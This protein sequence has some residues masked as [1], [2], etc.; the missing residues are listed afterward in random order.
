MYLRSEK[1]L[2]NFKIKSLVFL[3]VKWLRFCIIR[4]EL[5]CIRCL[6]LQIKNAGESSFEESKNES[7]AT[8]LICN[9]SLRFIP[10]FID[11]AK[12]FNTYFL[13]FEMDPHI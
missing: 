6:F 10:L 13:T 5:H 1:N 8:V 3:F 11:T 4:F 12:K 7:Q 2:F 9:C